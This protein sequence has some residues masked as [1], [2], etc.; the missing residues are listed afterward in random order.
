MA[1]LWSM[2]NSLQVIVQMG[3]FD[4]SL[5][6][7]V[8]TLLSKLNLVTSFS[9]FPTDD[10]FALFIELSKTEPFDDQWAIVGRSGRCAISNHGFF[11]CVILCCLIY[12]LVWAIVKVAGGLSISVAV[13]ARTMQK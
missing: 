1:L 12:V 10:F 13:L 5:P 4:M 7:N 2:I 9:F 6:G 3:F 11:F 8:L